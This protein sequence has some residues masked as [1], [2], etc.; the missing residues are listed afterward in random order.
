MSES[1]SLY[2]KN[3]RIGVK[4]AKKLGVPKRKLVEEQL[5]RDMEW[6]AIN[7]ESFWGDPESAF[8]MRNAKI[9]N[10]YVYRIEKNNH[11]EMNQVMLDHTLAL[12]RSFRHLDGLSVLDLVQ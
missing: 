3:N 6:R 11:K 5:A 12:T 7:R 8:H 10:D 1:D 2:R 4:I 9:E